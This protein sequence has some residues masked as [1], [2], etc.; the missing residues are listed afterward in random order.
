MLARAS[1]VPLLCLGIPAN[2]VIGVIMGG[3]LM[4]GVTPG[5][6][7]L[8]DLGGL[9]EQN[10]RQGLIIGFGDPR[11]FIRSPISAGKLFAAAVAVVAPAAWRL[12]RR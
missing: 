4:Q 9:F 2:A 12:A 7:L 3:L 11:A 6:R 10:L 8:I 1:F 5:P